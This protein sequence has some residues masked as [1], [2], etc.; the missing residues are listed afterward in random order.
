MT[1]ST[2]AHGLSRRS[3]LAFAG[4]GAV[5]AATTAFAMPAWGVDAMRPGAVRAPRLTGQDRQIINQLRPAR[6]VD[7]LTYL[8]EVVG[9]RYTGTPEEAKAADYIAD[10]LDR[11][12]YDVLV[13]RFDVPDRTLGTLS[14]AGLDTRFGWGVGSA[15]QAVQD[16]TVTGRLLVVDSGTPGDLPADLSGHIVMRVISVR[17]ED[18]TPWAVA[19]AERGAVAVIAT[20]ADSTPP[21]QASAFTPRLAV[22]R[23]DIPVVGVGQ[24]QKHQLLGL[25][26][27]AEVTLQTIAYRNPRSANVVG[28]RAGRKGP[29]HAARER[30]MLGAHYDS[31]IGSR[32]ANDNGSGTAVCL[33]LARVMAKAPTHTDLSFGFWGSEEVGLVGSRLHAQN[34]EQSERDRLRGVFNNDMVATSWEPS[35]KYWL[36]DLHGRSNPVNRA[37]LAAGDRLGYRTSMGEVFEMGRSDH[38]SFSEVGVDSGNFGWLHRDGFILEPEYHSSDDTVA[39][40]ISL[41]RLTVSMEIQGCAAYALATA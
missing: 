29:R 13:E 35:E 8:T 12:G 39:R 16:A 30:V 31:V 24:V 22:E 37:V 21:S 5:G 33:E 10:Q 3:F 7:D 1:A 32:G 23:V 27:G 19:A 20:R 26:D 34:L 40:N 6:A 15:P 36:L 2:S 9:Q 28:T 38:A 17:S 25:G 11:A 4:A 14:G 18:V 41:D